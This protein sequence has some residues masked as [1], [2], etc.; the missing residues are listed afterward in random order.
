MTGPGSFQWNLNSYAAFWYCHR[1]AGGSVGLHLVQSLE[2]VT[3]K[4]G[5]NVAWVALSCLVAASQAGAAELAV[6]NPS[7]E[8]PQTQ[9]VAT[10]ATGWTIAGPVELGAGGVFANTPAGSPGHISNAVGNQLAFMN[11]GTGN[12]FSQQLSSVYEAGQQYRLEA[13]LAVSA[14]VA[15]LP[16][17]ALRLG[18]Y[19]L[20]GA[21][22]QLLASE[23][24]VN[25]AGTLSGSELRYFDVVT[26][27]LAAGHPAIG[28]PIVISLA[29]VGTGTGFFDMD[30]VGVSTVVPEPCAVGALAVGMLWMARRR[31]RIVG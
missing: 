8:S 30:A 22:R 16:T 3:V 26:P 25:S 13:G 20:D 31:R 19:Y 11:S 10:E 6:V 14:S 12:E 24:V 9:F 23:D 17:D 5:R 27:L 2:E 4:V 28:K 15:P 18:L 1:A 21:Q 29:S 7:F